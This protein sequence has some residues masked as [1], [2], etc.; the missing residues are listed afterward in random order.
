ETVGYAA[1]G[2]ET[3]AAGVVPASSRKPWPSPG[4]RPR[5][6]MVGSVDPVGAARRYAQ[7]HT[8]EAYGAAAPD[9]RAPRSGADPRRGGPV[10]DTRA[11]PLGIVRTHVGSFHAQDPFHPQVRRAGRDAG[12]AHAGRLGRAERHP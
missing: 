5:L 9:V 10:R 4:S 1:E 11:P 6:G 2:N 7:S 12:D 8:A 3:A